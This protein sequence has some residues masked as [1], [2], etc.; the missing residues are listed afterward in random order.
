[1]DRISRPISQNW[2]SDISDALVYTERQLSPVVQVESIGEENTST[3]YYSDETGSITYSNT[4][5]IRQYES[6][7]SIIC[8]Q[9]P[10]QHLKSIDQHLLR[11]F[12]RVVSRTLSV[13]HEDDLNPFLNLIVPLAG[14]S[15]VVQE[16]LLALS[17]CHLRRIYPEVLQRGL[18]H[19]NEA[20]ASLSNLI[21][22]KSPNSS[23]ETLA[24]ILLLCMI[25]IC[26]GNS[27][28]WSWHI[29]A[30]QTIIRSKQKDLG[31][32]SSTWRFLLAVFGYVDSVITISKCQA[33]LISPEELV[34]DRDTSSNIE[35]SQR[36]LTPISKSHNEALFGIA[37]PLFTLIGQISELAHRRKDRVDEI[38]ELWF[39][40]SATRIQTSLRSWKPDL[41]T[42][43]GIG[44]HTSQDLIDAAYA[45]QWA[46]ILRL[47]QVV[48]G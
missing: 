9:S 2:L 8:S 18:S 21:G 29:Q 15:K 36:P 24:A 46:S 28:K 43:K 35:S 26:D 44:S 39:R 31:C 23:E 22:T 7:L 33:P 20:L 14:S 37:L 30:A 13:V 4:P 10:F 45:I 6:P 12:I 19:Q 32:N 11:H 3:P 27:T 25:E 17:A 40:Q 48:E 16:S 47:H 5:A 38:S 42:S 41:H 34:G 1:V